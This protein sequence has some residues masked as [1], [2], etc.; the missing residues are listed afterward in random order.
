MSIQATRRD[1][2]DAGEATSGTFEADKP[3]RGVGCSGVEAVAEAHRLACEIEELLAHRADDAELYGM[4]LARA[5]AQ[6]LIDQLADLSR[7][8]KR[9]KFG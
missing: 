6:S 9:P 1:A 8:S 2:S 3:L 4:R 7:D 5:L